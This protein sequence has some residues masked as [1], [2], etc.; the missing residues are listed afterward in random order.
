MILKYLLVICCTLQ[1]TVSL[2]VRSFLE[3]CP[4]ECACGNVFFHD[5]SVSRWIVG[6]NEPQSILESENVPESRHPNAVHDGS[7]MFDNNEV[8]Y[9]TCIIQDSTVVSH[10]IGNLS[11]NLEALILLSTNEGVNLT[12]PSSLL[13]P[14]K[15]LKTLEIR[16]KAQGKLTLTIDEPLPQL[17]NANFDSLLLAG[18]ENVKPTEPTTPQTY[19][20]NIDNTPRKLNLSF[21]K[22]EEIKHYDEYIAE[23]KKVSAPTFLGWENLK[24]L[25]IYNSN[26]ETLQWEH[27]EGLQSLK[28]LSLEKNNI[29]II[30]EFALFGALN[31]KTL[32]LANNE[33][34]DLHYRA[35][36]G[37]LELKTLDLSNNKMV[38][39]SEYTFP[40]FPKLEYINLKGNPIRYL[41]PT[42]FIVM[43]QT[44]EMSLDSS[45]EMSLMFEVPLYEEMWLFQDL[46]M[47]QTLS[48]SKISLDVLDD[49]IFRHLE[50]LKVLEINHSK[51]KRISFD[52]FMELRKLKELYLPT[53]GIEEL[54]MDTFNGLDNIEIIDLS[55]NKLKFIPPG[56]FTRLGKIRE[57]FLNNNKLK[58]LPQDLFTV[59]SPS[60]KMMRLTEN[61]W[62]CSCEMTIWKA[63]ITNQVRLLPE[64]LCVTDMISGEVMCK[65]IYKYKFDNKM[66]PRC[67]NV[68]K[69]SVYYALRKNLKCPRNKNEQAKKK[70]KMKIFRTNNE[71][72]RS[73]EIH[74]FD[75][76]K[77]K[78]HQKRIP[79]LEDAI[80]DNN[81]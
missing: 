23:R 37:L 52:A 25:R 70:R 1:L 13:K 9:A 41:F 24:I 57:I 17:E 74:D 35:L 7:E 54:S 59:A 61:P 55:K 3:S 43:N 38:H 80:V 5:L 53:C 6:I 15:L 68:K 79:Y 63:K 19:S 32:S 67:E 51:M 45:S 69:R 16:S 44:K 47:L 8:F 20:F 21:E 27:F 58:F 4:N 33:I 76:R 64:E 48:L 49:T 36:A 39:L 50:D 26:L 28:H 71:S 30:T 56:L 65:R 29:K 75:V 81:I 34:L 62:K 10:L 78:P 11:V 73:N 12:L 14:L 2:G 77:K 22:F 72:R 31:L 60:L 40:P 46:K 42:T 18:T 66:T